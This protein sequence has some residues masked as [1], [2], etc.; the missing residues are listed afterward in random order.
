M[1]YLD[2]LKEFELTEFNRTKP[3]IGIDADFYEA[4][5]SFLSLDI[6][7]RVIPLVSKTFKEI[8]TSQVV[9][10]PFFNK[11]PKKFKSSI[12]PSIY[13]KC[14]FY[15]QTGYSPL[16]NI[17]FVLQNA[18][19]H[20]LIPGDGINGRLFKEVPFFNNDLLTNI[21]MDSQ[22]WEEKDLQI[23]KYM[24]T[25]DLLP[26]LIKNPHLNNRPSLIETALRLG[27]NPNQDFTVDVF[28]EQKLTTP[29]HALIVEALFDRRYEA[30]VRSLLDHGAQSPDLEYFGTPAAYMQ[31]TAREHL[32]FYQ[33]RVISFFTNKKIARLL[34]A[35]DRLQQLL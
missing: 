4:P 17:R 22:S 23:K 13:Q 8:G 9:W 19:W 16:K 24:K 10:E 3:E 32:H 35:R 14:I 26:F 28:F 27:S 29:L 5:F 34:R 30:V 21:K 1:S 2:K 12:G 20:F 15:L 25:N 7:V 6:L 11:L 18:N 33:M 31:R